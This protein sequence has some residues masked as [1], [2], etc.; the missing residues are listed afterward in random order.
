MKRISHVWET[1]VS[2]DTLREAARRAC[3][4]R[5]DKAEVAEFMSD[6]DG[7]LAR[8]RGS[9][10]DGTY[11]SSEYRTF[12][13]R[14]NG[15]ERLIADLPLCPDRIVHWAVALAV[16]GPLNRRLI[17]QCYGSVPGRGH[18]MAVR[19]LE[20][21]VRGDSRVRYAL[22][23]DVRKFF[24][25]IDKEILKGMLRRAFKDARALAL[26]EQIVGEYPLPGIPL[27]NRTSPMFANLYLSGLDHA[28]KQAQ[29]CHYY[30][31]YMDDMVVL[32]YSKQWLHRIR[33]RVSEMLA[34]VGLELKGSW[35]VYPIESRGIDFLGYRVFRTHTLLRKRTKTRMERA[36]ARLSTVT[37]PTPRDLGT[38]R[39]YE[40]V[41]KWC[42]GR[43]LHRKYVAPV[44]EAWQK[45]AGE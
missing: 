13:I 41:L 28:L 18:H 43:N 7:N 45:A 1:I 33:A 31:R 15:K 23:M 30:L 3:R 32:G 12:T 26:M 8:I 22:S 36:M 44:R 6:M 38:L 4:A 42:D 40:G 37:V 20:S 35:Q 9:L 19:R 17:D 14:E 27:G 24:P 34:E 11:H 5:R 29:K 2:A 39:S 16:E 25:S 10:L 21:Y